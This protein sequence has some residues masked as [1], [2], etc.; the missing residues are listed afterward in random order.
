MGKPFHSFIEIRTKRKRERERVK[1]RKSEG[2]IEREKE[3]ERCIKESEK[4]L[5]LFKSI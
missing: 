4:H 2:E 3:T 1:E 5:N